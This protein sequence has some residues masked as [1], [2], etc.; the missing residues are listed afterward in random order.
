[1]KQ[2]YTEAELKAML[3]KHEGDEEVVVLVRSHLSLY[4]LTKAVHLAGR[5]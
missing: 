2:L 4:E 1:M 3:E 5:G